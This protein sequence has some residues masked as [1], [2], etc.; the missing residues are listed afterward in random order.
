MRKQLLHGIAYLCL[1]HQRKVLL[2]FF[3]FFGLAFFVTGRLR[4]DPDFLK[5]F[6]AEKGPIKLYM[7]NLKET[8]AFDLLFIL[9]E[10]KEGAEPKKL[11]DSGKTIVKKLKGMEVNGEKAFRSI[12]FQKV[13]EEDF[14]KAKPVFALFLSH[15]Y[16]FLNEEDI[17]KLKKKWTEEEISRQIKKNKKILVSHASFVM[18]DLIQTDPFELRWLFIEKWKE[19]MKGMEF[20]ETSNFFLSKDQKSLLI[21]TEPSQPATDLRFSKSLMEEFDKTILPQ[22]ESSTKIYLTGAHPIAT[23]EAEVL[24]FD[25]QSSFLISLVLVLILFFYVFRR[26]ITF[27]IIGLPLFGGIQLTMGIAS[28]TLRSLNILTIAFAA[29]LVGLGIDFAIHLY[30]RYHQE[31]A[32]GKN[33]S[34]AIEIALTETGSGIWTGAFTTIFAFIVLF[35]SRVRGITELAF[36]VAIGL[37]C[38]LLCIYFVLP[39]FL[40]LMDQRKKPYPYSYI[41]ILSF[42]YTSTLIEKHPLPIFI[43]FIGVTVL[44]SLLCFDIE[45]EKDFR[46]LRPKDIPPIE[47]FDQMAKAFGG[48]KLE[49]ISIH[50]GKEFRDLLLKEEEWVRVLEK[51]QREGK[52]DSYHSL[53]KLIPSLEKQKRVA[54][55][56]RELIDL[57]GVKKNFIKAL[58]E[59]GFEVG[60]FQTVIQRID[61]LRRGNERLYPPEILFASLQQGPFKKVIE[62]FV[63]KKDGS[64]RFI[65][66]I[67]YRKGEVSF[68]QLEKE[69]SGVSIT[70]PQRVELEILRIVR[71]DL[72]LL[73]PV[74]FF[75]VFLIVTLHFRNWRITLL[76]LSPLTMGLL[77]MVGTISLLGIKINFI[78]AV[79]IP[80]II[81]MGIDNSI[82]LMHRY[83]EGGRKDPG[84]ALRTT[85]RAMVL[86]SLTTMLGFG[87]LATARYQA[88]STMGWATIFGMGF[89]LVT[90]LFFL[91]TILILLKGT[92]GKG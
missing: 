19:G 27:L 80:M 33:I 79:I 81:G 17:E 52:I 67:Y 2:I 55:A 84:N 63:T 10:N 11:I 42:K 60:E 58:R 59:N 91:P 41:K 18:K 3:I 44:F 50:E 35:F 57:E 36:L 6:P 77:W 88:V 61:E 15:P 22:K 39:S 12:R 62:P 30:D 82:H 1:Y 32:S 89:C 4:F 29:I 40:V 31:R 8:G 74:A 72:Y 66:H 45:V 48:R 46:N 24:R 23:A 76:I 34:C 85:G 16:L 14:E 38:S 28:L 25:M 78:N 20:D 9:L 90:A 87:S 26:W 5:L 54:M 71:E 83:L 65:S 49:G 73:T 92:N 37:L 75:I 47:V 13:E 53:S 69:V 43:G 64:Y 86:C 21:I 56:I 70:G 7:E 51:Y 68:D